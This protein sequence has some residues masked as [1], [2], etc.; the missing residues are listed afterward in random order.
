[1]RQLKASSSVWSSERFEGFGWQGGYA[2]FSVGVSEI[3]RV[4]AYI[5]NQEAQHQKWTSADELRQ[6]LIENDVEF[7]EKYFE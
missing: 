7:D 5:Q 1:M 2:A 6:L 3:A 4:T